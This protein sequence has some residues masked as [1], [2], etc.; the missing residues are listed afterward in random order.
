MAPSAMRVRPAPLPRWA[1]AGVVALAMGLVAV[2]VL[3]LI[4]IQDRPPSRVPWVRV[5]DLFDGRLLVSWGAATDDVALAAYRVYRDGLRIEEV[6]GTVANVTDDGLPIDVLFV[7]R[8][9]AVDSSGQEGPPSNEATG[10][11]APAPPDIAF[12]GW[13]K[14]SP[15]EASIDIASASGLVELSRFGVALVANGSVVVL[16]P[17]SPAALPATRDNVTLSFVDAGPLGPDGRLGP[18]DRFVLVGAKPETSYALRLL[19]V[20]TSEVLVTSDAVTF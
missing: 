14:T 15:S 6:P 9:T 7:Y 8:V 16:S 10:V 13:S 1:L 20:P 11:S 4:A 12:E 3:A 2:G 17:R 5:D 19:Y 18:G